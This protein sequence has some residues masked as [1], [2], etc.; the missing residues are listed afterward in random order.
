MRYVELQ[1]DDDSD[2]ETKDEA[3]GSFPPSTPAS[4]FEGLF[5]RTQQSIVS[6]RSGCVVVLPLLTAR[7]PLPRTASGCEHPA[8]VPRSRDACRL[9]IAD[10]RFSPFRRRLSPCSSSL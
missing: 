8:R 6:R 2:T 3:R 1:T 10:C 7:L 9:L 4:A 5:K